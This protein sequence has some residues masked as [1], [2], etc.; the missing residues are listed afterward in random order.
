MSGVQSRLSFPI[1][2]WMMNGVTAYGRE[3]ISREEGRSWRSE[4]GGGGRRGG[5]RHSS[6]NNSWDELRQ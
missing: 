1:V 5:G 6:S 3:G 2:I 4:K